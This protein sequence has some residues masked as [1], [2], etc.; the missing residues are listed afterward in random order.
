MKRQKWYNGKK[1]L[2]V[3]ASEGIG[4]AVASLLLE[5]GAHVAVLSRDQNKLES[6]FNKLSAQKQNVQQRL[7]SACLDASDSEQVER[8]FSNLSSE[9]G[10]ADIV[11]NCV[12]YARPGYLQELAVADFENMM[13]SNYLSCVYISRSIV[14]AMIGNGGGHLVHTSSIAGFVGLFG[15]TGY[16]AAK[17]AV[18]GFCQALRQE[19]CHEGVKVSVLCPP[20]TDTPGLKTENQ[21]KPQELLAVEE[22]AQ[23]MSAPAVAQALLKQLPS[24][25]F[26]IH[27]SYDGKIAH[28]LSRYW[29]WMLEKMVRR[30]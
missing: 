16:C 30:P 10:V 17:F 23:P 27:P 14:P 25:S 26:L 20:N 18:I 7:L 1:A 3:G 8:V 28:W 15:Y 24:K 29:P 21:Y 2:V 12:G 6:A 5:Y 22:K 11:I 13:Q 19:L 4:F 9:F